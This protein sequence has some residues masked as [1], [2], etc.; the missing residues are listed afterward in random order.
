MLAQRLWWASFFT[1][2]ITLMRADRDDAPAYLRSRGW[3]H[4]FRVWAVPAVVGITITTGLLQAGNSAFRQTVTSASAS[5]HSSQR[6]VAQIVQP[7]PSR[8][9][10]EHERL[11]QRQVDHDMQAW[12]AKQLQS[13]QPSQQ[14]ANVRQTV[15]HA[16]N[17]I[18]RG[19]DN[20]VRFQSTQASYEVDKHE[21]SSQG[22]RVTVVGETRDMKEQ[23]C[24]VFREGSL[25]KRNCKFDVGLSWRSRR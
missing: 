13:H 5:N 14:P 3:K 21:S 1:K 4:A 16:G 25:E 8:E 12:K 9:A 6:P 11:I 20:V 10:S 18:P 23:A 24:S 19:A 7:L 22:V 2:G 17:Y 15:F